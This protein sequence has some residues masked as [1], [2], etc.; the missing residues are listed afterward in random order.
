MDATGCAASWAT[1]DIFRYDEASPGSCDASLVL[2]L[3]FGIV[4][5][6]LKFLTAV[7]I[8]HLWRRRSEGKATSQYKNRWPVVPILTWLSFL[9]HVLFWVLVGLNQVSR[10]YACILVASIWLAF[11]FP[12]FIYNLKFVSLGLGASPRLKKWKNVRGDESRLTKMDGVER[13]LFALMVVCI[14]G[15]AICQVILA[16]IYYD[17]P[18]PLFAGVALEGAFTFL[19]LCFLVIHIRRLLRS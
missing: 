16:P 6:V 12:Y 15:V 4:A 9:A 10:G 18:R 11:A 2:W 8:L 13:V 7:I 14:T 3:C 17:D 1:D 5:I 19:I